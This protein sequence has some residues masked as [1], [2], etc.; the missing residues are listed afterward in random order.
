MIFPS[1]I[2]LVHNLS[3]G[4]IF[5]W[6][7]H[8]VSSEIEQSLGLWKVVETGLIKSD[9]ELC[10]F[11]CLLGS[12][13]LLLFSRER[14]EILFFVLFSLAT[15][16]LLCSLLLLR[17]LNTTISQMMMFKVKKKKDHCCSMSSK[18][19]YDFDTAMWPPSFMRWSLY[20]KEAKASGI[21]NAAANQH[22][23]TP[24]STTH[25]KMWSD[26]HESQKNCLLNLI[27][28]HKKHPA[29]LLLSSKIDVLMM[30]IIIILIAGI[31]SQ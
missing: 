20:K 11:C 27:E 23:R 29:R 30:L 6:I 14:Q 26:C 5:S 28:Y 8:A 13:V 7:P 15:T 2:D 1:Q 17:G 16:A 25:Q 31:L 19:G 3:L 21:K 4:P 9:L 12:L 22:F 10:C 18:N 24:R